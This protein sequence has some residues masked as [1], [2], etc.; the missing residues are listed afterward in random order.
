M[1]II[2]RVLCKVYNEKDI[3]NGTF[4][5][6][7][8]IR[9]IKANAFRSCTNLKRIIIPDCVKRIDEKAFLRCSNLETITIGAGVCKI[10]PLAFFGCTHLSNIYYTGSLSQWCNITFEDQNSSPMCY[11]GRLYI[12]NERLT[13]LIVP[14][15]V[16]IVKDY[17]FLNCWDLTNVI[18][19]GNVNEIGAYAF[20]GCE[21]L[22]S[23]LIE[24]GVKRIDEC[25]F[26]GCEN[27]KD[28]MIPYTVEHIGPFA[29]AGVKH[30]GKIS[31]VPATIAAVKGFYRKEG[32][33]VSKTGFVY[34]IGKK[35]RE[36]EA[37]LCFSGFHA[38]LYGADVFNYYYD[39]DRYDVEYYQVLLS[40]VTIETDDDSKVCGK[41]LKIVKHLTVAEVAHYVSDVVAE[42]GDENEWETTGLDLALKG[43]I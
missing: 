24:P 30:M 12:N 10:G 18:I 17:A 33:L 3:E 35:Y 16:T 37:T 1:E 26:S 22:I 32:K 38:C 41:E 39:N 13:Q 7:D 34:K 6:P 5:I 36:P 4:Q 29:F 28:L 20:R 23:A 8:G 42:F 19:H 40:D 2:K 43:E 25:A 21:N 31:T 9:R 15:D 14:D 11:L 27:L